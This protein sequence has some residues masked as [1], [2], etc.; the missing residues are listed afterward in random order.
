[1]CMEVEA[2]TDHTLQNRQAEQAKKIDKNYRE[3]FQPLERELVGLAMDD[4]FVG[5]SASDAY[6]AA[7][8]A[9]DAGEGSTARGLAGFGMNL[10]PDQQKALD[11]KRAMGRNT[12]TM[13]AASTARQ[14]AETLQGNIKSNMLSIGRGVQAQGLS[15]LNQAAGM[16]SGRNQASH[17]AAG[18]KTSQN[19]QTAGTIATIGGLAMFSERKKKKNIK[20]RSDEQDMADVRRIDNHEYDYKEGMSGGR[21]EQGHI[22]PMA[23]DAPASIS[24]GKTIDIGDMQSLGLGAI[25]NLD[26]RLKK[27]EGRSQNES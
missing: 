17:N 6:Q 13:G 14:N 25:R 20:P 21:R 1:M 24:D 2:A 16:E 5:K 26:K 7:G 27:M 15:G 12:A 3:V 23:D 22:G 19:Y 10:T 8:K 4:K 9:F 11:F 18:Q